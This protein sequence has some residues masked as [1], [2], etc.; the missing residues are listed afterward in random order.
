MT[1][2]GKAHNQVIT[3]VARELLGFIR[4]IAQHLTTPR[5]TAA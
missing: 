2:R 3:A 1:A 4:A 5:T